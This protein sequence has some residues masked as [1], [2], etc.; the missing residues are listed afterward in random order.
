LASGQA[1]FLTGASP[2]GR[3]GLTLASETSGTAVTM[4]AGS[5][6]M[7]REI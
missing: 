5:L 7:Y 3:F 1:Y 6:L 2:S 4:K